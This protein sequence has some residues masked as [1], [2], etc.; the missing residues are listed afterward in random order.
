MSS[1]EVRLISHRE[2][3][4]PALLIKNVGRLSPR[5]RNPCDYVFRSWKPFHLRRLPLALPHK[6]GRGSRFDE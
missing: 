4:F 5:R 1:E 2:G 3:W 6:L